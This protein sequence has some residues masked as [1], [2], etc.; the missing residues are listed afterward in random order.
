MADRSR[1]PPIRVRTTNH[2]PQSSVVSTTDLFAF[3]AQQNAAPHPRFRG[4]GCHLA[5]PTSRADLPRRSEPSFGRYRRST[6]D[7]PT[8]RRNAFPR[9]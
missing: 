9:T 4:A 7:A 2:A 6:D 1:T 5:R 8:A 3:D